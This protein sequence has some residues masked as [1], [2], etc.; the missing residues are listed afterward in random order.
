MIT[1]DEITY[2]VNA[3]GGNEECAVMLSVC[4]K[5]VRNWKNKGVKSPRKEKQIRA[6]GKKL[7][8]R[9]DNWRRDRDNG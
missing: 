7:A 8:K 4:E 9:K 5:T 6:L 3:A 2:I 1:P